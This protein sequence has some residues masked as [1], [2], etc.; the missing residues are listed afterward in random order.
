M[1]L[2]NDNNRYENIEHL[3]VR[4]ILGTISD[5]DLKILNNWRGESEKNEA[6]FNK[7]VSLENLNKNIER[8]VV[9]DD[10]LE[11]EWNRIR[12]KINFTKSRRQPLW[13]YVKYAAILL[14]PLLIAAGIFLSE[15][16][17]NRK[18]E[19]QEKDNEVFASIIYNGSKAKLILPE[20]EVLTLGG[21]ESVE[22]LTA[23]NSNLK[24]V[25]DTLKYKSSVPTPLMS[26]A[27]HTLVV[28][29]GSDF[30]VILSDGT[31]V[32]L[33]SESELK[34]PISFAADNRSVTVKGEAFF[35]VSKD[36]NRPF[37][38]NMGGMEI[39][40]LGTSFATRYF[41]NENKFYT[42]LVEGSVTLRSGSKRCLLS[43][44][45]QAVVDSVNDELHIKEVN[46]ELY[47][48]W[49]EGKI[50]F[51]RA[52]LHSILSYLSRLY[53]VDF[54]YENVNV[55]DVL[56]SLNISKYDSFLQIK[57]LLEKTNKV[58]FEIDNEHDINRIIVK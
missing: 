47:T 19:Q 42:T 43:P 21:G 30:S 15:Y 36:V 33:N 3:I 26:M 31:K 25:G 40:V 24:E 54:V 6:L 48:S 34:Y 20:G 53:S 49:K 18:T 5:G 12:G 27:Y 45:Q 29:R 17:H 37:I 51:D 16:R 55:R 56:F 58:A 39:K 44:G 38:V 52:P 50:V 10:K 8:F 23:Q 35:E 32:Y 41:E 9:S 1:E 7:L 57:E 22:E 2:F 46:T 28:P 11:E 14:V 4:Y 13:S